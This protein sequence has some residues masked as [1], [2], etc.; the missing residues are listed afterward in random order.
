MCLEKN[1]L[2]LIYTDFKTK[3]FAAFRGVFGISFER[4][5]GKITKIK[6]VWCTSKL[7]GLK[8]LTYP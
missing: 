6:R 4:E 5:R 3:I 2:I 7:T 8:T 1:W